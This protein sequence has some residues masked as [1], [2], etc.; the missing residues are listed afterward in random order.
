MFNATEAV[1][2]SLTEFVKLIMKFRQLRAKQVA[3]VVLWR[4]LW[5]SCVAVLPTRPS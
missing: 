3:E 2:L 5:R 1:K 4:A